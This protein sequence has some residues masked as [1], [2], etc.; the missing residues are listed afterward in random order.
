M[1]DIKGYEGLYGITSCGRVW[2][3]ITNKFLKLYTGRGGYMRVKLCKDGVRKNFYVHRLVAEAYIENPDNLPQVNH[4]DGNK[5]HNWIK[6]LEWCSCSENVK[7]AVKSG[8]LAKKHS[9]KRVH[10][11]ET[12]RVYKS[13]AAAARELGLCKSSVWDACNGRYHTTG[14]YHFT[15]VD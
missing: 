14:G 7:H 8:L 6:N 3:Y 11:V 9:K 2:S 4:I 1:I 5:E 10:C 12:G 13:C 15:Y